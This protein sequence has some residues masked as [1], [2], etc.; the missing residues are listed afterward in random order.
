MA[1]AITP[2]K[3]AILDEALSFPENPN[4]K[5]IIQKAKDRGWLSPEFRPGMKLEQDDKAGPSKAYSIAKGI[6]QGAT[7]GLSEEAQP[8]AEKGIAA[9]GAVGGSLTEK[10]GQLLGSKGMEEKGAAWKATGQRVLAEPYSK[11]LAEGRAELSEAAQNKGSYTLG[12]IIGSIPLGIGTSGAAAGGLVSKVAGTALAKK[13]A[14]EA[15]KQVSKITPQILTAMGTGAAAGLGYS[16]DK[17]V[18]DAV[19]GA[20]ISGALAGIATATPKALEGMAIS[21]GRRAT[22]MIKSVVNQLH[23]KDKSATAN[24]A[25]RAMLD[26]KALK[27]NLQEIAEN[28]ATLQD[29]SG[30]YI[31]DAIEA[32]DKIGGNN[33]FNPKKLAVEMLQTKNVKTGMTLAQEL[34]LPINADLKNQFEKIV[35]TASASAFS[36]GTLKAAQTFKQT[37]QDRINFAKDAQDRNLYL[38]AYNMTRDLIDNGIETMW[39]K[40]QEIAPKLKELNIYEKFKEAKRVYSATKDVEKGLDSALRSATGNRILSL[41]DFV[42][43]SRGNLAQGVAE[44]AAKKFIES[45]RVLSAGARGLYGLAGKVGGQTGLTTAIVP[46]QAGIQSQKQ[47]EK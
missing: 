24:K 46:S 44:V 16:D 21:L 19:K 2:E 20:A 11:Q 36:S 14:V 39:S 6:E 41:T 4:S 12:N 22:G 3:K 8:I 35:E 45:P 27:G 38:K 15:T 13:G 32:F 43:M 42:L 28:V 30:K 29:E 26:N 34:D 37:L 33:V 25:I 9:V 40:V 5:I 10:I 18:S 31:G 7:L 17:K 47:G 1:E 23:G